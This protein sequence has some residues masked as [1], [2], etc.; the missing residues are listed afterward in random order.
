V[1]TQEQEF[2]LQNETMMREFNEVSRRL[3]AFDVFPRFVVAIETQLI[4]L[5]R[6]FVVDECNNDSREYR[7]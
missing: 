7:E 3:F 4:E 6:A 1:H 2:K 5:T